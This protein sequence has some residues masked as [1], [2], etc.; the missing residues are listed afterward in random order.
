MLFQPSLGKNVLKKVD[1]PYKQGEEGIPTLYRMTLSPDNKVVVA[2]DGE[3]IYSGS[4]EAD[5]DLLEAKEIDDENDKKPEDWVSY[6][7]FE[8]LKGY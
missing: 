3:E 4:M 2:A 6:L 1:L 8:V 5:W 7:C